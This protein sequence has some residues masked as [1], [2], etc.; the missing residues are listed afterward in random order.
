MILQAVEAA[1]LSLGIVKA[2]VVLAL[3]NEG[4]DKQLAAYIV[5]DS[6]VSKKKI[7]DQLRLKLPFY[8]I[9]AYIMFLER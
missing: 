7:R 9:P 1:L 8:M 2:C 6:D 5:R 3:G 4:E